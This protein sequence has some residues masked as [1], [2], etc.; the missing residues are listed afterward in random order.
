MKTVYLPVKRG[1][2]RWQENDL[3]RCKHLRVLVNHPATDDQPAFQLV[4]VDIL[5]VYADS[6]GR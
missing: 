1:D 3:L 2:W 5:S 4:L 6:S